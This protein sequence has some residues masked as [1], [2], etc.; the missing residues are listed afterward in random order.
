M[1][2]FFNNIKEECYLDYAI[3]V[4]LED[5]ADIVPIDNDDIDFDQNNPKDVKES[6]NFLQ[7][8]Y[9]KFMK[10]IRWIIDFIIKIKNKIVSWFRSLTNSDTTEK[11]DDDVE[12]DNTSDEKQLISVFFNERTIEYFHGAIERVIDNIT[13]QLNKVK[14]K[15]TEEDLSDDDIRIYLTSDTATFNNQDELL[16]MIRKDLSNSSDFAESIRFDSDIYDKKFKSFQK[17]LTT[18]IDILLKRCK[19]LYSNAERL[20]KNIKNA[21]EETVRNYKL[22]S[23]S[24]NNISKL[25]SES[26][27]LLN[28]VLTKAT[29]EW[30]NIR[31][32]INV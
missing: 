24:L 31:K 19:G 5:A 16:N 14:D 32:Q 10:F 28:D 22:I 18:T 23:F 25:F 3:N 15:Y 13:K 26:I 12:S 2:R 1:S 29:A 27:K 20:K 7:K 17:K 21:G 4:Y 11:N 8:I 9:D 30:V 6:R